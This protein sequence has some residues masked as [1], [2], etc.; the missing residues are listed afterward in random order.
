MSAQ[1][2]IL[3]GNSAGATIIF[4][5]LNRLGDHSLF[6]SAI[7]SAS[8]VYDL[9][10]LIEEFPQYAS[11]IE[12]AFGEDR[13]VWK[14]ASPTWIIRQPGAYAGYEGNI[15][16]IQSDDDDLMPS[17]KQTH[18]FLAAT[19]TLKR[20]P[21]VVATVGRHDDVPSGKDMANAVEL[22]LADLIPG[23]KSSG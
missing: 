15:I 1:R 17:W 16:L 19:D 10:G 9:V 20:K 18:E 14:S 21:L 2:Y 8:G 12:G 23:K 3:S 5:V 6:P 13:E 11:L 7:V 22:L 4:Q